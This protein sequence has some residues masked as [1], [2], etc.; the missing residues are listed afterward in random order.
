[1]RY[2]WTFAGTVFLA[3]GVAGIILPMLPGTVFLLI[4]SA[5][6]VRGSRR[7][8]DWLIT[9]PVLGHHIRVMKGEAKMPVAA[10]VTAIASMWTAVILSCFAAKVLVA[11]IVIVALALFGTW[12][13]V[14]RR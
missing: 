3:I 9:H 5:C 1:V 10:K 14:W 12:F 2:L 11:Q 6:Y 4:A 13:I 7:L 8:H